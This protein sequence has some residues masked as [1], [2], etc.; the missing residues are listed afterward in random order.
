MTFKV[1]ESISIRKLND[2]FW[3][4]FRPFFTYIIDNKVK[5]KKS[6][7]RLFNQ[8][9]L[10]ERLIIIRELV[11]CFF[12]F[13]VNNIIFGNLFSFKPENVNEI[14]ILKSM[15]CN[16]YPLNIR[17][18]VKSILAEKLLSDNWVSR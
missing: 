1:L 11:T 14:E 5:K 9:I 3:G 18:D 10:L 8:I 7:F 13:N 12:L 16:E 2:L 15:A 6:K 4:Y 17:K